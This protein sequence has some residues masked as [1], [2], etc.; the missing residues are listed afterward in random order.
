MELEKEAV[1]FEIGNKGDKQK[2]FF[3]VK[4]AVGPFASKHAA[5]EYLENVK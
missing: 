3:A 2:G 4:S 5:E 1:Y